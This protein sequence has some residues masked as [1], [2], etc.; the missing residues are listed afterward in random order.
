MAVFRVWSGSAW[1]LPYFVYPKYW[2]GTA[3]TY[4][5]PK[6]WNGSAWIENQLLD[7]QTITV[8]SHTVIVGSLFSGGYIYTL[9][10]YSPPYGSIATGASAIYPGKNITSLYFN[11]LNSTL[12]MTIPLAVNS[13]WTYMY[14]G[15]EIA[16]HK[17]MREDATYGSSGSWTWTI[18]ANPF[19]ADGSTT[20]VTFY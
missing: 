18:A 4:I 5:T 8:G 10:G 20:P 2:D 13:G 11:S 6:I 19:G 14:V 3:W 12:T 7:T 1:Q 15:S 16:A 9:Y 17:H